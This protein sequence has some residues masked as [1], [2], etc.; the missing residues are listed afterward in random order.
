[1]SMTTKPPPEGVPRIA[2][3]LLCADV[4]A[5]IAFLEHAFGLA[6]IEEEIFRND[7]GEIVH[8]SLNL[9]EATV[10][11]GCPGPDY[12]NPRT[13]GERHAML[14]VHVD[15]ADAHH[16]RARAAGAEIVT[17]PEDAFYGDRRYAARDPEGHEWWFASRP[18]ERS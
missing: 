7:E 2:P 11:L 13:S 5:E 1:M 17:P 6:R 9:G 18:G 16:G 3:Y 4:A 10:H 8:A 15:D 14:Y 12:R